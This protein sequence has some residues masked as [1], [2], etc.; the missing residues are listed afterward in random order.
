M[1]A[2]DNYCVNN[3]G[4]WWLS[5]NGNFFVKEL[6]HKIIR[7]KSD[8]ANGVLFMRG[9]SIGGFGVLHHGII[10]DAKAVYANIHKLDFWDQL[11]RIK[12]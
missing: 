1:E 5:E 4:S 3:R 12:E 9:S 10:L 7:L 8:G 6:L 2:I 11:I